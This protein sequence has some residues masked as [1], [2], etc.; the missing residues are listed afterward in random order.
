MTTKKPRTK[1]R[2][3][4]RNPL[5]A[6]REERPLHLLASVISRLHEVHVDEDE[7]ETPGF[8]DIELST[9]PWVSGTRSAVYF[10]PISSELFLGQDLPHDRVAACAMWSKSVR[11]LLDGLRD[12][13]RSLGANA[14]VGLAVSLDPFA[15]SRDGSKGMRLRSVGTAVRAEPL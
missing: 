14:V 7:D 2:H 3:P 8:E 6:G 11:E 1:G 10:G 5:K 4:T 12:K 15:Q 9:S 13:A